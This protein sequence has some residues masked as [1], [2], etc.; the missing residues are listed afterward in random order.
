[1]STL[2]FVPNQSTPLSTTAAGLRL[3]IAAALASS[4]RLWLPGRLSGYRPEPIPQPASWWHPWR[5]LPEAPPPP[6]ARLETHLA[7]QQLQAEVPVGVYGQFDAG[8]DV[9][10]SAPRRGWRIARTRVSFG[11]F[12]G[13]TCSAI[14]GPGPGVSRVT[15][16]VLPPATTLPADSGRLTFSFLGDRPAAPVQRLLRS[17]AERNFLCYL[18]CVPSDREDVQA[19]LALAL[20]GH[21]WPHGHLVFVPAV[22]ADAG[23]S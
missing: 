4:R 2:G 15:L 19:E 18:A 5:R 20:A 7:G 21:G 10:L 14:L 1:M 22:L 11:S 12:Q 17:H 8:F 3:H 6:L 9:P 13:E 16:V 23:A